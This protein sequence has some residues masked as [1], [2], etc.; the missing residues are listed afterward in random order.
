MNEFPGYD[1]REYP[2]GIYNVTEGQRGADATLIIGSSAT[3]LYDCGMAYAYKETLRSLKERLGGR[4][5]DYILVSHT[6]YDH[7]GALPYILDEY[8]DA[9]AVGSEYGRYVFTRPGARELIKKLGIAAE[10]QYGTGHPEIIKSE[11]VR[12]DIVCHDGDEIDLGDRK[13]VCLETPGHTNCCMSFAVE[14]DGILFASESTGVCTG[15]GECNTAI[16]KDYDEAMDS[17]RKCRDYGAKRIISAHYG[18]TPEWYS[19]E[20]FDVFRKAAEEEKEYVT[21]LWEEGLSEEEMLERASR[22]AFSEER[23]GNQ[24]YEAFLENTKAILKVYRKYAKVGKER[25]R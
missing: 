19:K 20:Y 7:I 24:P 9:K 10:M 18:I 15:P 13:I 8:P 17:M 2:E 14:P 21:G 5:L 1:R 12:I 6:H 3:A 22:D 11:G 4:P 25:D 23:A 16:L